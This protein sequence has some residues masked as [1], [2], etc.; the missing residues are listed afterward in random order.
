MNQNLAAN[1]PRIALTIDGPRPQYIAAKAT[2]EQC[3]IGSK[4]SQ[5]NGQCAMDQ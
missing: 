2:R 4:V 1:R 5:E 3:D